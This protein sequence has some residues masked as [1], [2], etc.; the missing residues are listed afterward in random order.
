MPQDEVIALIGE[1]MIRSTTA[2]GHKCHDYETFTVGYSDDRRVDHIGFLPGSH[3]E[4]N[5]VDLFN[6]LSF[7]KLLEMDGEAMELLGAVVLLNLGIALDGFDADDGSGKGIA[8][9]VK[10]EYDGLRHRMTPFSL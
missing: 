8:V 7:N 6:P 5:G 4:L 2:G 9:F 10:G 1:P 3:V